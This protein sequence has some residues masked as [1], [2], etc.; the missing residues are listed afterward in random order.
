MKQIYKS[1]V[2]PHL[3]YCSQ[4][5]MPVDI[6]EIEKIEKLQRDFFRKIPELKNLNYWESL[7]KMKMLSLQ[8]RQERYR[9]IYC[10]KILSGFA[11]NCGIEEL[12]WSAESILGRRLKVPVNKSN[13]KCEELR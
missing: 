3:D 2:I 13:S 10:W 5:W 12:E 8:R 11:P 7:E 9:V 1:L 6:S 4:L